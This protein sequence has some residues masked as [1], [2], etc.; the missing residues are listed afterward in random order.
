MY[1]IPDELDL[2]CVI[3]EFTTQ[4]H[5][6]KYDLQFSLGKVHFSI[7]SPILLFDSE[8]EVGMWQEGKWPDPAFIE[9]FNVSVTECVIR[10]NRHIILR[11]ENGFEMH[12]ADASD[13]YESMS[14]S[15]EGESGPW[16]I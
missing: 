15:I 4:I 7:W 10:D 8:K 11:F 3:G 12:L 14:I 13:E 9:L 6:G 16:I 1:R 5:V 2:S